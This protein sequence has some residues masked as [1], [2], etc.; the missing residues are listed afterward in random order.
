VTGGD[1]DKQM[2]G[3][4]RIGADRAAVAAV[5]VVVAV[6][7]ATWWLVGD[8]TTPRVKRLRE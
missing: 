1:G 5:V 6:P 3:L 2:S 4:T 8:Q 7:V